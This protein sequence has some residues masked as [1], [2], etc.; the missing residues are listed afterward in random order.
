MIKILVV[1]DEADVEALITQ[2]FRRKIKRGEWDLVFRR[3]GEE[4]LEALKKDPRIDILLSDINMPKMDGL[5]LLQKVNESNHD[6]RTIM[7][8]AYSDIDNIRVA[9]NNGA[10]DF[11]TKPINFQDMETTIQR[12]FANLE[13][14]RKALRSHDDLLVLKKELNLAQKIQQS[15]LPKEFDLHENCSFEGMMFAAKEVGGDYY[16]LFKLDSERIA[17]L[18]ADVSGKGV[19]AALFAMVNQTLIRSMSSGLN[20]STGDLISKVNAKT[21]E[22]NEN[23]MFVTLF[24]TIFNVKTGELTYTNA[25]HNP[26]VLIH[27]DGRTEFLPLTGGVP[28]GI[29]EG[30]EFAEK[31]MTLKPGDTVF[32][33]TDGITEAINPQGEEFG[34]SRL[35]E[36]LSANA[37]SD[38]KTLSQDVHQKVMDFAQGADQFDDLTYLCFRY[39][40][41]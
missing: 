20:T 1:D 16:D 7:V 4:A 24:Y 3:N 9:M 38:L 36:A 40:P 23:C 6:L 32:I 35:L 25:G 26:P 41:K 2:K 28:L 30:E 8:S 5:T 12:S 11:I 15:L 10:F 21:S 29:S 22:N 39:G 19:P 18:V 13:E 37:T 14:M 27:E 17:C 34:D 33:Y 31:S